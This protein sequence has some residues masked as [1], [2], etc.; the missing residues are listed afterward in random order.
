[1]KNIQKRTGGVI[2]APGER[3]TDGSALPR[4]EPY[5]RSWGGYVTGGASYREVA[6][7]V[8]CKKCL[9]KTQSEHETEQH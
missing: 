1:M 6:A 9:K 8:T 3:F 2:H 5:G 7:A 4:C